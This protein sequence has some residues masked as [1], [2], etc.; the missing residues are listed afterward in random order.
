MQ[1]EKVNEGMNQ[2]VSNRLD[3]SNKPNKPNKG[4][5]KWIK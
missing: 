2:Y 5:K 3:K 4:V 1:L